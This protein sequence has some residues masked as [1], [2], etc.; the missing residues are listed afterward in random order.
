MHLAF[1][2][3][4]SGTGQHIK[5][6]HCCLH[7]VD[8]VSLVTFRS[9]PVSWVECCQWQQKG[10][11]PGAPSAD[12]SQ[13]WAARQVDDES[14]LPGLA[15]ASGGAT[16]SWVWGRAP[17]GLW[18]GVGKLGQCRVSARSVPGQCHTSSAP[19]PGSQL[20]HVLQ[21]ASPAHGTTV[22]CGHSR[23][24]WGEATGA[25]VLARG[26]D[27]TCRGAWHLQVPSVTSR[28]PGE[29]RQPWRG[30]RAHAC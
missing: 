3:I 1:F 20:T 4:K 10:V 28:C 29:L 11:G 19:C 5:C 30:Q 6:R 22:H 18:R 13:I 27:G 8:A 24:F 21:A 15:R 25:G 23:G 12:G 7:V 16:G 17:P 14:W 2:V 26:C 9:Q